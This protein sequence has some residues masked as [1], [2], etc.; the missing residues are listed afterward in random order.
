MEI[1]LTDKGIKTAKIALK[2]WKEHH[3]QMFECLTQKEKE[4]LLFTLKK[5]NKDWENRF[6]FDSENI[7]Q[8]KIKR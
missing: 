8:D 3:I 1:V 5:I 2:E 7:V 6:S 4:Q